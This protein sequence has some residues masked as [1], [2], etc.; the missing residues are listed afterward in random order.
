MLIDTF[1]RLGKGLDEE[2]RRRQQVAS[3]LDGDGERPD[4]IDPDG[5]GAELDLRLY[6]EEEGSH[7]AA[8]N[9]E[10]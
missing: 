2:R 6:R 10:G 8:E 7:A 4:R 9:A 3:D 5:V 1:S